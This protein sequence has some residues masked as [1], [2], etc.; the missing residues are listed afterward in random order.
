MRALAV[1]T[2]LDN[3]EFPSNVDMKKFANFLCILTALLAH[4]AALAALL[5]A[6]VIFHELSQL[7]KLDVRG[8]AFVVNNI[9][10]SATDHG[11]TNP[12]TGTNSGQ[13][14]QIR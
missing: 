12:N 3:L 8:F 9:T 6:Y 11:P 1:S 4:R 5:G 2:Y 14:T 10:I 13:L 7:V